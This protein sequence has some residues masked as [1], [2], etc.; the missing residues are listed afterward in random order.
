MDSFL[1]PTVVNKKRSTNLFE[2]TLYWGSRIPRHLSNT[3]LIKIQRPQ[4]LWKLGYTWKFFI[5]ELQSN[6][7]R[8][9]AFY[10]LS[11][12]YRK[13]ENNLFF[14]IQVENYKT[15]Q[16]R[17]SALPNSLRR[18]IGYSSKT[19]SQAYM[20]FHLSWYDVQLR[21]SIFSKLS[22]FLAKT[23]SIFSK[24][25]QGNEITKKL[26]QL[27]NS[28]GNSNNIDS[29]SNHSSSQ[30]SHKMSGDLKEYIF[31]ATA[32]ILFT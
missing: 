14:N 13:V 21:N 5:G 4:I 27:F 19:I 20:L 12:N 6:T 28:L 23:L 25:V 17:Q 32:G 1:L 18:F 22:L 15:K 7:D 16:K 2:K 24:V 26:S 30:K 9:S 31:C 8:T 29:E 10:R 11:L 3:W